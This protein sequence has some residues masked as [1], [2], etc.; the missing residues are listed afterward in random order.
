MSSSDEP[1]PADAT[2][3]AAAVS[4][5]ASP[6]PA[7]EPAD[8]AL[9]PMTPSPVDVGAESEAAA[10]EEQEEFSSPQVASPISEAKLR[11]FKQRLS[12]FVNASG[13]L[14][15]EQVAH[16]AAELGYPMKHA[17][18]FEAAVDEMDAN[19]SGDIDASEFEAVRGA[20]THTHTHTRLGA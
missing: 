18:D 11:N 6:A 10:D 14:T 7:A 12:A 17:G 20:H 1:A 9:H 2:A 15:L 5:A 19:G 3:G 16:L 4:P 8:L 13:Q